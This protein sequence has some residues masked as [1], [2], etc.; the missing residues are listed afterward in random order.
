MTTATVSL[1]ET[2]NGWSNFETWNVSLW[3]QNDKF[4][5][6]TAKA[7]VEFCSDDETPYAKFI[8]CMSNVD[9][10]ATEDGVR[11]DDPKVNVAEI[12]DM[13]EGL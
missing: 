13:M 8:R 3:M 5:Y 12:L 10:Y 4:L 7:C 6:N 1:T 11:Y 9:V 2:Y